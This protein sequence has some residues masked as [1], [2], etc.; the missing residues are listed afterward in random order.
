MLV[1]RMTAAAQF[2]WAT[3][4]ALLLQLKM[5]TDAVIVEGIPAVTR[6]T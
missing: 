1:R 6:H 5:A 4:T 2:R 3:G